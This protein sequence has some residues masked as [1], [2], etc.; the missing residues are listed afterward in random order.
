MIEIKSLSKSFGKKVVLEDVNLCFEYGKITGLY[1]DSGCGKSTLAKILCGIEK[2]GKGEIYADG[3]L[4]CSDKVKYKRKVGKRIQTVYQQP[5]AA[6]DPV[7]RIG[8]SLY[9]IVSYNKLAKSRAE[10]KAV[11]ENIAVEMNLA[12]ETLGSF[13]SAISGGEAQRVAIAKCLLL[14]PKLLILD[15]ATSM[16]DV[17]TQANVLARIKELVIKRNMGVLLISHDKELVEN[18]CDSVYTYENCNFV[19]KNTKGETDDEAL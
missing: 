5:Y 11:V 6:L 1:G 19:L 8:A 15:E 17:S 18:F 12:K 4:V 14:S 3:E 16:L 9:E 13:P 10:Q 7:Q 2:L